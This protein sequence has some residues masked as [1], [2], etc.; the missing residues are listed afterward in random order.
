MP[1]IPSSLSKK[2]GGTAQ[3]A[4]RILIVEDNVIIAML[5][6][7][8]LADMGHEV[9]AVEGS[10]AGA[11]AAAARHR[12]DL[13]IVDAGLD[14]GSGISAVDRILR[15]GFVPHIFVSG[16]VLNPEQ[17]DPRAVRVSKP[18]N[19]WDLFAAIKQALATPLT[20]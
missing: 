4:L 1:P 7:A 17:L 19:E 12:P 15:D 13:L 6:A 20:I 18:Y 3:T 14:E 11:V 9:C 5:L 16:A 2:S 8:T 10:E